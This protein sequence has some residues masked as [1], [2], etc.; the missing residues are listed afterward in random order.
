MKTTTAHIQLSPSLV[1]TAQDIEAL[2]SLPDNMPDIKLTA[3]Q[4]AIVDTIYSR[5]IGRYIDN[6]E[7]IPI[8]EQDRKTERNWPSGPRM[9]RHEAKRIILGWLLSE[10][11]LIGQPIERLVIH[12]LTACRCRPIYA[13][14]VGMAYNN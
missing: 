8:Y 3:K 12:F 4:I 5:Y 1:M 2:N 11:S 13:K 10:Q 14:F 6:R 7:Y 9:K